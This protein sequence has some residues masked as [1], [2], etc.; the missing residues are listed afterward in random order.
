VDS[1]ATG[2]NT[3]ENWTNAF[4][5]L[6]DGIRSVSTCGVQEIWVAKGTYYPDHGKGITIGSRDASFGLKNNLAIYGGFS[7]GETLLSQR[8]WAGNKT[9]LSG[10]IGDTSVF[11]DN[12]F[13]VVEGPAAVAGAILD[14][15]T[16]TAGN[17]DANTG[18]NPASRGGG[19]YVDDNGAPTIK[20]CRFLKNY[21]IYGGAVFVRDN[22]HATFSNCV[23]MGNDCAGDGSCIYNRPGSKTN[24]I[25]CSFTGNLAGAIGNGS[26]IGVVIKN[27]IIWGNGGSFTRNLATV[28]NCIVEGGYAG[29]NNLNQDPLFV[30][31]P[32]IAFGSTGNLHLQPCSP[33]IDA[34]D[35][36]ATA[37]ITDLDGTNRKVKLLSNTNLVDMGAYERSG[38]MTT[39][40]VDTNAT[41]KGDGSGW[42]NAYQ[43]FY[44]ALQVYNGCM[45]TDS[46]LIAAG[47]YLAPAGTPFMLT[48]INGVLLGGYP[49]GGGSRNPAINKVIIKGEMQVK[50]SIRIDGIKVQ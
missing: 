9:T 20:N 21:A 16:I 47:T 46:V 24:M 14:G 37:S 13:S 17:G 39:V 1:N 38:S 18:I 35:D 12:S 25:N 5:N 42:A 45:A 28:S 44:E 10:E 49:T 29:T 36:A 8:N 50:E 6:Q 19:L 43:S 3:G 7:G 30:A 26:D 31:Q 22:S 4:K 2:T 15:F 23:F 40:Y 41:G 27:S 32:A 33:A 11:G 34:G 48:K